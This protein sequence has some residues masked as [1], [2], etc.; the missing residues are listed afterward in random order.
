M[1]E[2]RGRSPLT[3]RAYAYVRDGIM[4]GQFPAG[5]ALAEEE[6][7]AAL[8]NSRTPVRH[9]LGQLLQEGLLEVGPRRQ[10]V[11]R[12]F[13]AEHRAEILMLREALEGL[14][15][16][17]ACGVIDEDG[18]DALRL[19]LLKQWR[20][21][22]AG[23]GERFIDLDEEF[24]LGIARAARLPILFRVLGQLR[25]FVR[26]VRLGAVR[27]PSVLAR[28]V[29]EHERIVDA[30]ERRDPDAALEALR[31]HL[32]TSEY[33]IRNGGSGK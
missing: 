24:H 5:S 30:L 6:I 7:A 4:R 14:A 13:T 27:P 18:V 9:A 29:A 31:S 26:V 3:D 17:R 20:A 16:R 8:K 32:Y 11:V 22:R 19:L 15:V 25:G 2:A 28:V 12:G 33:A 10:L 1:N 21:A 23:D